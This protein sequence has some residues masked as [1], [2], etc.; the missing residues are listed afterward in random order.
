MVLN[1]ALGIIPV[2]MEFMHVLLQRP[3]SKQNQ[4]HMYHQ[5][6]M[7]LQVHP[8]PRRVP[9]QNACTVSSC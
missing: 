5:N 6:L 2:C 1:I 4:I 9:V 3:D 8:F 7:H